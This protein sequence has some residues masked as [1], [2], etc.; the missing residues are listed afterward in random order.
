M[1]HMIGDPDDLSEP[2]YYCAKCFA[3]LNEQVNPE[4]ME[5]TKCGASIESEHDWL[6]HSEW[7]TESCKI[8]CALSDWT[9][10]NSKAKS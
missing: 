2:P 8:E 3:V 6:T 10:L 5:C 7:A 9:A 1:K 4:E